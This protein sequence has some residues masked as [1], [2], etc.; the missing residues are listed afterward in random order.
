MLPLSPL[1]SAALFSLCRAAEDGEGPGW[2]LGPPPHQSCLP[3]SSLPHCTGQGLYTTA[4][5]R[6][7]L[8]SLTICSS[9][10]ILPNF[11]LMSDKK[12]GDIP[13][14][15]VSSVPGW[16]LPGVLRGGPSGLLWGFKKAHHLLSGTSPEEVSWIRPQTGCEAL[17]GRGSMC[18]GGQA[19]ASEL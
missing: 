9:V 14:V 3:F 5:A 7:P 16:R 13:L 1:S 15:G 12:L 8:V 17:F 11:S 4:P 18:S 6:L 10:Q 2:S 19:C